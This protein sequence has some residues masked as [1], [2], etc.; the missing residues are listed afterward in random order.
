MR[1]TK[2]TCWAVWA[3]G[4]YGSSLAT[5][6]STRG[7]DPYT[8]TC[9]YGAEAMVARVATCHAAVDTKSAIM[10]VLLLLVVVVVVVVV[11]AVVVH[12]LLFRE[13]LL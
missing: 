9:W 8:T 12:A 1:G 5:S 4:A 6:D 10:L 13:R 7:D 3:D 11:V 2:S